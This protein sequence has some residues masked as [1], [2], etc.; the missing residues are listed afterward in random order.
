MKT[1][2]G[3]YGDFLFGTPEFDVRFDALA[4]SLTLHASG[5]PITDPPIYE[6]TGEIAVRVAAALIVLHRRHDLAGRVISRMMRGRGAPAWNE[7]AG[8]WYRCGK[9]V[10]QRPA[11]QEAA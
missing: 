3:R 1:T 9:H 10:L 7:A 5:A 8:G 11:S 2:P 4:V 6:A